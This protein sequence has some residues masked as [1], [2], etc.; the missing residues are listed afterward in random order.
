MNT[1]PITSEEQHA[2]LI[3]ALR[4]WGLDYLTADV[5]STPQPT[6]PPIQREQLDA[7]YREILPQMGHGRYFNRDAARFAAQYAAAVQR[8]WAELA[9][10]GQP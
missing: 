7:A 6:I 3:A 5:S 9:E 1:A 4:A 8:A 2:A 10:E